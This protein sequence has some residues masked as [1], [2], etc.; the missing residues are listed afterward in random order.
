[1]PRKRL[2]ATGGFHHVEFATYGACGHRCSLWVR[3][4]PSASLELGESLEPKNPYQ[5]LSV[6]HLLWRISAQFPN[7]LN[8]RSARSPFPRPCLSKQKR[9]AV[10]PRRAFG[11]LGESLCLLRLG[12][13]VLRCA[14]HVVLHARRVK[15]G[16]RTDQLA[17]RFR[18]WMPLRYSCQLSSSAA[19]SP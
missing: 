16:R 2:R 9:A 4:R 8:G 5:R 18:A 7:N 11:S 3:V 10:L 12:S 17:K 14:C 6:P 15:V 1:M 19:S 13:A